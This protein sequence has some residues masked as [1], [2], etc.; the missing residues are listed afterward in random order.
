MS[1]TRSGADRPAG[2]PISFGVH[3]ALEYLCGLLVLFSVVRASGVGV[4]VVL[5]A[6][7]AVVALAAVTDGPLCAL[8]WLSRRSHAVGDVFVALG[9]GTAAVVLAVRDVLGPVIVL[10]VATAFQLF[11]TASTDYRPPARRTLPTAAALARW[12]GRAWGVRRGRRPGR[13]PPRPP[14]GG[15]SA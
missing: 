7:G 4:P 8:R 5:A 13:P 12:A 11:L 15:P 3:Q 10:A 1:P 2:R 6:G 14:G 9:L